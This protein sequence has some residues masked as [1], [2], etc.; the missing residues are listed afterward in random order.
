MVYSD[1]GHGMLTITV[2][3][4]TRHTERLPLSPDVSR[5]RVPSLQAFIVFAERKSQIRTGMS[6]ER[7]F[8]RPAMS[9]RCMLTSRSA[10]YVCLVV[11]GSDTSVNRRF[12]PIR[13]TCDQ[14]G[15]S[16]GPPCCA[17]VIV[18]FAR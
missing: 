8:C 11:G 10:T 1:E 13:R 9:R 16:A 4:L 6:Y 12:V 3:A 2:A 18:F 15:S 17:G 7:C 14:P 5:K